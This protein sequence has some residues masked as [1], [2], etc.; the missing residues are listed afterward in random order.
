MIFHDHDGNNRIRYHNLYLVNAF[1][2]GRKLHVALMGSGIKLNITFYVSMEA[3]Y[4]I[5]SK[6]Y[7]FC[8]IL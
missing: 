3:M 6:H 8:L 5:S 7:T 4:I 1:L 2:E